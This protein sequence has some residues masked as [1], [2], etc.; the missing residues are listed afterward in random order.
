MPTPP[1]VVLDREFTRGPLLDPARAK[2]LERLLVRGV[3]LPA[4]VKPVW[5]CMGHGITVASDVGEVPAALEHRFGTVLVEQFVDGEAG[6]IEV[7]GTPGRYVFGHPAWTG[8][9]VE[10]LVGDFDRVRV[11]HP[12]LFGAV[13]DEALRARLATALSAIGFS[14]A[15]C[16][17]F[18]VREGRLWVLE[19]NPRISGISVLSSAATGV[20]S[21]EAVYRIAMGEWDEHA[22]APAQG[23]AIQAGGESADRL[24][25][26]A[27]PDVAVLR[28]RTIV[29]DGAES[30]S[31]VV[32]GALTQVEALLGEMDVRPP[33]LLPRVVVGAA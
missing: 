18:V 25:R 31:V 21:F 29:V 24:A 16:V 22:A 26:L 10:G 13:L 32:S 17:D 30:R 33:G 8:A 5:D 20:N 3:G 28:D 11:S 7:L 12:G 15:C 23:A 27:G 14:G 6:S 2:D 9:A 4:V 1:W 19:I